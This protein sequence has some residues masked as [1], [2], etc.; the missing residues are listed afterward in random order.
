MTRPSGAAFQATG[1]ESRSMRSAGA[2][3][4]AV[5]AVV[6]LVLV[7]CR[8][9]P[10]PGDTSQTDPPVDTTDTL[11]SPPDDTPATY[12]P[13]LYSCEEIA[14]ATA[15]CAE[16]TFADRQFLRIRVGESVCVNTVGLGMHCWG[17][18]FNGAESSG[19][20]PWFPDGVERR[21]DWRNA[22]GRL[23]GW[24]VNAVLG[25]LR[26][27]QPEDPRAQG[28]P[29]ISDPDWCLTFTGEYVLDTFG[30]VARPAA[31]GT[32]S[33]VEGFA[34][35]SYLAAMGFAANSGCAWRRDGTVECHMPD[36][37]EQAWLNGRRWRM[38]AKYGDFGACGINEGGTIDCYPKPG[39]EPILPVGE[40]ASKLHGRVPCYLDA[41]GRVQC[42]EG[43]GTGYPSETDGFVDFDQGWYLACG[44]R[45]DD[46]VACWGPGADYDSWGI[47]WGPGGDVD[48]PDWRL[49]DVPTLEQMRAAWELQQRAP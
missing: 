3:F 48:H 29:E 26:N 27:L 45:A 32:F 7:A 4:P 25:W 31:Y 35:P 46:S 47:D 34:E 24:T 17:E 39:V 13:K 37:A 5:I 11:D 28:V 15:A 10:A 44:L 6:A 49:A 30:R 41:T 8:N 36:P 12:D 42:E 21:P 33:T 1:G 20:V 19:V 14:A 18:L 38:L 16:C 22:D 43:W 9:E 2:A 23:E 40:P